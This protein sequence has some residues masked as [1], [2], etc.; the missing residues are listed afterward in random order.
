MTESVQF[1]SG[2]SGR[3]KGVPLG[4]PDPKSG[5]V[6][7][8]WVVVQIGGGEIESFLQELRGWWKADGTYHAVKENFRTRVVSPGTNGQVVEYDSSVI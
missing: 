3:T 8:D 1:F 4:L 6:K 5:E 7:L 2:V